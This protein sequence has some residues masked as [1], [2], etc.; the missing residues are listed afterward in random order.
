[1]KMPHRPR[2][3]RVRL[4]T[5]CK[6]AV[7]AM[8]VAAALAATSAFA[9]TVNSIESIEV[10]YAKAG[11]TIVRLQLAAPAISAPA[12]TTINNPPRITLEFSDTVSGF[13]RR[14]VDV[15]DAVL[16][17]VNIVPDGNRT[18]VVFNLNKPQ[19]VD[20]QI[21]ADVIV[22][23]L[24]DR[25]QAVAKTAE[26][27]PAPPVVAQAMAPAAIRQESPSPPKAAAQSVPALIAPMAPPVQK[28]ATPVPQPP[29]PIPQAPQPIERALGRGMQETASK[30]AAAVK[31]PDDDA[32]DILGLDDAKK[33]P[34]EKD[35]AAGDEK[36]ARFAGFYQLESAYTT[37][38]PAHFSKLRNRLEASWSGQLSENL[39]WKLGGGVFYD[40][41]YDLSNF[42][43]REVR[44]DQ[45]YE[46]IARENYI[47]WSAGDFDFRFGRQHIIWGEVVSL[48]VA[49][50][51]S[52]QDL[53]EFVLPDFDLIRI[54][55]WA[56]RAEYFKND[57]HA[58]AIF[59][60]RVTV[61]R[62]GKP[63]A[64]FY[65]FPPGS[66]LGFAYVIEDEIKPSSSLSNASY[67]TRFS[68]LKNGWDA[69]AFY[70]RSTDVSPTFRRSIVESPVPA[71]VYTPVH[72][73]ISQ[74][75]ATLSK[76]F[77]SFVFKL[78]TVYTAGR[79]YNVGRLDA[80]N[81][82]VRQN[83]LDYIVAVDV[84]LPQDTRFNAQFFQRFFRKYDGETGF[85]RVESDV[86]FLISRQLTSTLTPEFLVVT[87]VN[88]NDWM[89]RPKVTWVF[90]KNWRLVGGADFFG[91][92]PTGYFGR[93]NDR[94]RGYF[95]LRYSF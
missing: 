25:P 56:A 53:R 58:E 60:P 74:T 14:V 70:Y 88:R 7:A 9:Q 52:A 91:G 21:A 12:S 69:A 64:D 20:A 34:V 78:E 35:I 18:K 55:Q 83:T 79:D 93:Y 8:L 47:D 90:A 31:Q 72:N 82:L 42:Y 39:K 2:D 46:A 29:Q 62:I 63:G 26:A 87:S 76:D 67:G 27:V 15:D 73:R 28:D 17:S 68:Y 37:P 13:K 19:F 75:G 48:F 51:V 86:S 50:V 92:S 32:D 80:A 77:D 10:T 57:F 4:L 59:V 95:E 3:P 30:P 44:R 6:G 1:M 41:I 66:P 89:I 5:G 45:R 71:F 36:G 40:A 38:S 65:P 61:D 16:R 54:P 24:S 43:P 22:V 11:K 23:T 33:T 81:G 49:D 94:D 85:N 84:P